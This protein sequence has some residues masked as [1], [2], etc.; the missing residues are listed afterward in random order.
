[1]RWN[2]LVRQCLRRVHSPAHD[3]HRLRLGR[4]ETKGST[5]HE[6]EPTYV[7]F[8]PSRPGNAICCSHVTRSP[9]AFSPSCSPDLPSPHILRSLSNVK[10]VSVHTSHSGC[11]AIVLTL[12]GD[13]FLF[14]RNSNGALGIP[15]SVGFVSETSPIKL[16]PASL[17]AAPGIKFVHAACGRNHSILVGSVGQ[18]WAAGANNVGQVHRHSGSLGRQR[19]LTTFPIVRPITLF[20]NGQFQSSLGMAEP[21]YISSPEI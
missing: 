8:S 1:M 2:R 9:N 17:G 11:H 6:H 12:E 5:K 18:V 16:K 14:G 4:K 10:V 7:P 19:L 21:E 20:R 15:S 13:A 3:D